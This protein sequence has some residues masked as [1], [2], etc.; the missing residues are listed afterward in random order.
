MPDGILNPE[1]IDAKDEQPYQVE[2][3][4]FVPIVVMADGRLNP[5]GIEAKDEQLSQV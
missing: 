1:G 5:D 4:K 3:R 2:L